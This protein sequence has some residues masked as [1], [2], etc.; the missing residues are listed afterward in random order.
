MKPVTKLLC[1]CGES[2]ILD[3]DPDHS[4]AIVPCTSCGKTM[5]LTKSLKI[6]QV[7]D[8]C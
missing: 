2:W 8:E 3:V 5:K 6:E 4:T 7:V 1:E